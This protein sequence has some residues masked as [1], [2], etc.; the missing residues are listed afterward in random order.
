[1][2]ETDQLRNFALASAPLSAAV[3]KYCDHVEHN[4]PA[5]TTWVADAGEKLGRLALEFAQAA[6]LD[7]VDLYANRLAGIESRNV[8]A[9]PGS[10]D[11][12]EAALAAET[13]RDLQ[14]VQ[15]AHDRAY[16]PDVVGLSK[17]DQLRHCAFHL[18]KLVGA[19][20]E[21]RDDDELIKRR[22]PDALLFAIKLRTVMGVHLSGDPLPP[23]A[24]D[25]AAEDR[26]TP[27]A[28]RRA[29]AAG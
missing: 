16:H 9:A 27:R 15:V 23:R 21:A 26:P 7:L 19:F 11:G 4:E 25:E 22:L 3:A 2:H 8:L 18:A 17:Y 10:F 5:E 14:L 29:Q 28:R 24:V 1:V 6:D 12:R 13:W 20:A